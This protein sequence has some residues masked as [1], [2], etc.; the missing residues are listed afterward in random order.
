MRYWKSDPNAQRDPTTGLTPHERHKAVGTVSA[1]LD[2][3]T[4]LPPKLLT[5]LKALIPEL[6][7]DA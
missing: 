1:W 5:A 3:R 2:G 6:K 7:N 4:H